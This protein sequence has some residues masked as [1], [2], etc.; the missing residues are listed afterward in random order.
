M[1][2]HF[3]F[4]FGMTIYLRLSFSPPLPHY[5]L[6][7][8]STSFRVVFKQKKRRLNLQIDQIALHWIGFLMYNR[9][10]CCNDLYSYGQGLKDVFTVYCTIQYCTVLY[11]TTLHCTVLD[12]RNM[13]GHQSVNDWVS[14]NSIFVNKAVL[15]VPFKGSPLNFHPTQA[16]SFT[17]YSSDQ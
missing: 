14:Q 7:S 1:F 17:F 4:Y 10:D 9:I 11:C 2:W 13:I 6:F 16:S 12:S 15:S 8:W 3:I 5:F